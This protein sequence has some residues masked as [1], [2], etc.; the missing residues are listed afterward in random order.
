MIISRCPSNWSVILKLDIIWFA[1]PY[2]V[3]VNTRV[4]AQILSLVDSCFPPNNTLQPIFN[5]KNIKICYRTTPNM[6]Q[7]ISRHNSKLSSRSANQTRPNSHC[8]CQAEPCPV[9]AKCHLEGVYQATV[10]HTSKE[11]K[12]EENE[13]YIGMTGTTFKDRYGTHRASWNRTK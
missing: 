12:K 3:N 13:T 8:K 4:G 1:P 10:T 9:E 11:T 5:R 7:I 6:K 2:S